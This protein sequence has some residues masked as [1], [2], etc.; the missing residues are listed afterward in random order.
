MVE[1]KHGSEKKVMMNITYK[2]GRDG[3]TVVDTI[4][5]ETYLC[6]S[7]EFLLAVAEV[8]LNANAESTAANKHFR[9][10]LATKEQGQ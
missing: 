4:V 2:Q 10:T 1:M 8:F 7:V 9:Q 5:E 6:A 3:T